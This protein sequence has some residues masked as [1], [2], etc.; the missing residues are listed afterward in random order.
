VSEGS[1][2]YTLKA[3]AYSS[4]SVM[5]NWLGEGHRRRLL[6]VGA[7]DGFLS[8]RLTDQ[9]WRVTAVEADPDLARVGAAACERMIVTDLNRA[10]PP[11]DGPFDAIVLGDILEHLAEPLLVLKEVVR[12]L[13]RN[14]FVVISVPNV[15][16]LW[17]RLSLLLGRF[18]YTDRGILDRGHLRFFTER[19]LRGLVTAAGLVIVRRA[20]TP[21][22]LHRVVAPRWHSAGLDA[23]QAV[24]ACAA[25]A[26]PRLLG[27]QFVVLAER[28]T[29]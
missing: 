13:A 24:G 6:D 4:H 19:T 11:L 27:Y 29:R 1:P 23:I 14:G 8:R 10:V 20:V 18:E 15:A 7:A 21:V 9:G 16:H 17:V 3:D 2:R 28:A 5:L 12:L 25:R 22:P 26:L